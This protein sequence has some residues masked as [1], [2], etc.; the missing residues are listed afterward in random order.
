MEGGR[1]RHAE[2]EGAPKEQAQVCKN[3]RQFSLTGY[4][5]VVADHGGRVAVA[6]AGGRAHPG[7][8]VLPEG[9]VQVEAV[10][11]AQGLGVVVAAHD[12]QTPPV[13]AHCERPARV[14][15]GAVP[16]VHVMVLSRLQALR[17]S[18]HMVAPHR[19]EGGAPLAVICC[20]DHVSVAPA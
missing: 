4:D 5:H 12:V 19:G 15:C 16:S 14:Q 9:A 1:N 3:R 10:D 7:A 2:Q 20:Q 13:I 8:D 17:P 6:R 18:P 11:V